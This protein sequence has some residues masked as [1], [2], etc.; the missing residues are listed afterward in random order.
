MI[1]FLGFWI[2]NSK[3]TPIY[4]ISDKMSFIE[5]GLAVISILFVSLVSSQLLDGEVERFSLLQRLIIILPLI[6]V[7]LYYYKKAPTKIH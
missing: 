4:N 2:L 7:G 6:I 5:K 3:M 1:L